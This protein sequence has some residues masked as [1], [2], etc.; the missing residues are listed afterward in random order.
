MEM[1]SQLPFLPT[2][3]KN[4]KNNTTSEESS[5][6]E[7]CQSVFPDIVDNFEDLTW[8]EGRAILAPTNKEVETINNM[9]CSWLP[10]NVEKFRSADTLDHSDDL[11]NFSIEYLNSLTP[12][13]IP[14]HTLSLKHG[15]PLM[16][17]RNINPKQ[18]LCNGTKLIYDR[19]LDNKVLVCT[20]ASTG[21]SVLIP[22]ITFIPKVG[23]YPF[24]W[25]RRQYPVRPAFACTI[26]KSQ[27]KFIIYKLLK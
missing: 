13:G 25:Q 24:G 10:G 27:G 26:N 9:I 15:M 3:T 20:V 12:N 16:L 7:F 21:K 6:K 1:E 11:I 8:L 14:G 18:G 17:M 2:C 4:S 23:E 19:A 5:M 22:R